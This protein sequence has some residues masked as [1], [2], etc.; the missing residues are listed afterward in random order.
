MS[1]N[2]ATVWPF[3]SAQL[4][5]GGARPLEDPTEDITDL[6][7]IYCAIANEILTI[8]EPFHG[9]TSTMLC[10][11]KI[12]SSHKAAGHIMPDKLIRGAVLQIWT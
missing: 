4:F 2:I 6:I 3:F 12:S 5:S 8:K 7:Q 11:G 1:P 10:S 9:G